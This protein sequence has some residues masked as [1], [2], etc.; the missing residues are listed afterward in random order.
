MIFMKISTTLNFNR[1]LEF[2]LQQTKWHN[3]LLILN[4]KSLSGDPYTPVI[5]ANTSKVKRRYIVGRIVSG[6][7][8]RDWLEKIHE[9]SPFSEISRDDLVSYE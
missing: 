2:A 4:G 7:F 1:A 8:R 9:I 6:A 5:I 3:G